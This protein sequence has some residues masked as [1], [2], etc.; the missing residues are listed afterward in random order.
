MRLPISP[1]I[2]YVGGFHFPDGDAA[3]HRVYGIGKALRD[4]GYE[5]VFLGAERIGRPQDATHGGRYQFDNFSYYPAGNTGDSPM[6]RALRLWRTHLSGLSAMSRLKMLWKDDSVAVFAYQASLPFLV[7][8]RSFCNLHHAVLVADV[9][10]WYDRRHVTWG[11][12]GPFALDSEL[13]MRYM[14]GRADGVVAISSYLERFYGHQGRPTLRV[15]ALVDTSADCWQRPRTEPGVKSSLQLAFVGRAGKKELLVN[16][17]RGLALLGNDARKWQL[18]MVGPDRAEL[19]LNL[20][21]DANLLERLNGTLRFVD[22][23]SHDE[24]LAHLG[25]ADFSILLRPD[26]RFAHAGFPTKLVES[27]AMGVPVICNLTSD[28]GLYVGDGREGLLIEDSS[29][30]AFAG[31]LR[32]AMSLSR[33]QRIVIREN[34]RQRARLSFDYRNWI[35]PIGE[36][37]R[38]VIE[39]RQQVRQWQS[40]S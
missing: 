12:Y 13:R 35:E 33:E 17:I 29:P 40:S 30:E 34:A 38:R 3:A 22:F 4:A 9:V 26:L 16:A 5:V 8:L 37:M 1:R 18:L 28:I 25:L 19:G 36:F 32:R 23:V 11:R 27:L 10:E 2:F 6:R 14:R 24:A 7:Q 39:N 15:P 31:G 21:R 20:G